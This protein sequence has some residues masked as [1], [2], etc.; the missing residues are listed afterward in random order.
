MNETDQ[1]EFVQLLAYL[2]DSKSS[3][4]LES[5]IQTL[6]EKGLK[7]LSEK[8]KQLKNTTN[9]V[10]QKKIMDEM[11][12]TC[13]TLLKKPYAKFGAKINYI[14][15]L[16][17]KCPEGTEL[18][19]V[20]GRVEC[21]KCGGNT[22]VK[23]T[24]K[25]RFQCGGE[26]FENEDVNL[27]IPRIDHVIT[28]SKPRFRFSAPFSNRDVSAELDAIQFDSKFPTDPVSVERH[29]L[30][31]PDYKDT[32]YTISPK[33]FNNSEL[34]EKRAEKIY[35]KSVKRFSKQSNKKK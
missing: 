28:T 18:Y 10:D 31:T 3:E 7:D 2:T 4:E 27:S 26:F 34:E 13:N 22:K 16:K 9:E 21:K 35:N 11:K 6:G 20:G 14:Q 5:V 1:K 33:L 30:I 19:K 24:S 17:N 15:A 12:S 25:Q 32:L 8:Y 23:P 29:V